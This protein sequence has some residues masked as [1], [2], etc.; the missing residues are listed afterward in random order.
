MIRSPLEAV[1]DALT[2]A[3]DSRGNKFVNRTAGPTKGAAGVKA[4][5][6]D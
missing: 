2:H 6:G 1:H 5:F 4:E 3:K